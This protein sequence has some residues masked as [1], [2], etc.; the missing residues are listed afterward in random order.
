VSHG[1]AGTATFDTARRS[2]PPR[3][4]NATASRRGETLAAF[5]R[6]TRVLR[7]AAIFL[8]LRWAFQLWLRIADSLG[9]HLAKLGL[10]LWRFAREG[11]CPCGHEHYVGMREGELN[12]YGRFA[13]ALKLQKNSPSGQRLLRFHPF[14]PPRFESIRVF[15]RAGLRV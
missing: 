7:L 4:H 13:L 5:A 10:G 3:K 1:K 6:T 12:P 14:A 8:G 9:Q 15:Q 2:T 11:F